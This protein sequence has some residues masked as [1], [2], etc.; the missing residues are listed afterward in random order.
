MRSIREVYV[1]AKR[2]PRFFLA[3]AGLALL[4]GCGGS[5]YFF[6][7]AFI[8]TV[9]GGI[10]PVT[11]GPEAPFVLVRVVNQTDQIVEFVITAQRK[12][13]VEDDNGIIQEDE[14]GV[15]ITRPEL[16]TVS[17]TT[18]PG[19]LSAQ[20]G[21][22][23]ECTQT[24]ISLIGLGENLLPTDAAVFVGGGGV[25]GETG[26]GV[27]AA[28]L[29]PLSLEVGNFN[30]GDTIIYQAFQSSGVTGGV[31][32]QSFLLPGSEQP[33]D[34][35]ENSNTFVNYWEFLQTQVREDEP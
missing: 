9:E 29:N 11:P 10:F 31:A 7:P 22:L 14:N 18:T 26:F 25:G 16:Q 28:N 3:G 5:A 20:L 35:P 24:S 23:F 1:S 13:F 15:R 27:P 19:G 33:S 21:T 30:C 32:L 12:V 34:F 8:N 17:L 2:L 6:N 4:V